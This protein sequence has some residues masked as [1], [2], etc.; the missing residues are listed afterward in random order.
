MLR[1]VLASALALL[2]ADRPASPQAAH[3][4]AHRAAGDTLPDASQLYTRAVQRLLRGAP[5]I[6]G[7]DVV[8]LPSGAAD[9]LAVRARRGAGPPVPA[10][11]ATVR[12]VV[13]ALARDG[14]RGVRAAAATRAG[15]GA[16]QLVLGELRYEPPADPRFARLRIAVIGVDGARE[17]TEFLM[18]REAAGGW[19]AFN[20]RIVGGR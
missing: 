16:L 2:A 5:D 10:T 7:A 13:V 4:A 3:A 15:G 6:T 9:G 18:L 17:T 19:R 12:A 20:M 11:G 8:L 14:V 1:L